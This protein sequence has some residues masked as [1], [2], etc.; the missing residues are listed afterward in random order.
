MAK[1]D[2]YEILG[3]DRGASEDEI[4]KAYR[5]HALKY[6]PDRNKDN[7]QAEEMFKEGAEAYEVLM[8]AQK[9]QAYDRF[10]HEGVSSTFRGG[11]FQWSD[12]SHAGDFQDIFSNLDEIFGGGIFGD[13]FGRRSPRRSN[14]G[15]D[16]RIS[17][18]LTLEEI[19]EGAQ[20]T[21]R[22]SR[23]E[24]CD[25]CGGAGAKPGSSPVTCDMC[26]GVGQI[27]QA[28]RSLFGQFVNVTT[29]PQCNGNGNVVRERCDSCQGQ[30]R[31][32][33]QKD[34]SVNIPA[35][36][37]EGNYIPLR[38][39]GNAGPNGGPAGDCM[40]F[41]EEEEHD[42]FE[43]HGND[44]V[45]DLPISFS[46]AAL[47][48]D[49]EV[50]TL[51]GRVSMKIPAGTQSGRIFRLRGKGIP[52]LDGYRTGDQLVRVAV[53]TPAKLSREEEELFA[54]LAKLENIQPPEGGKGFFERFKEAFG[55]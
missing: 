32:K 18:S 6:H 12:F 1:R 52:E 34:L 11:G 38:G 7:P 17:I 55:G 28:T 27:R 3:V 33:K 31:V 8:D 19:A 24:T 4:K 5:K 49:I 15:E 43:R 44:I 45:Y 23:L 41:V 26:G 10:G 20:K 14:R 40:V 9:R 21:I 53:W 29:C 51:T 25:T 30:G 37:S 50:P 47:G 42:Y 54:K 48:A 16:L 35:G 22:L 13:L 39:Q 2:Y 36:I 46:Q